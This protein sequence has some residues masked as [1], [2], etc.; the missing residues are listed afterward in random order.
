MK[1]II[2]ALHTLTLFRLKE[3][4]R[5][6]SDSLYW[7]PIIGFFIGLILCSVYWLWNIL[8]LPDWNLAI[9]LL[10]IIAEIVVTGAL[11][12]DGLSDWA[13]SLGT[14][15]KRKRLQIMKD[16]HTGTFGTIAIF[17]DLICRLI[18][19]LKILELNKIICLLLVP[20]ISRTMMVEMCTGMPYARDNGTG[21]PF[22]KGAKTSHRITA[23]SLCGLICLIYG[24]KGMYI[25]LITFVF[26]FIIK[27]GFK[28][29]FGGIT[30]DLLGATN[31]ITTILSLFIGALL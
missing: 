24:L 12:I 21:A 10:M 30:G 25:F 4:K 31:E 22:V 5:D 27:Q 3:V 13:D 29:S 19:F 8:K 15:E 2:L 9:S 17:V 1:G 6:F 28:R 26:T 11:H 7:F 14:F 20:V 18:F 16:P 23:L